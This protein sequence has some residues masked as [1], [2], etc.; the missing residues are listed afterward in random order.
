[1]YIKLSD[2]RRR[3]RD[4]IERDSERRSDEKEP[5]V[6]AVS[7]SPSLSSLASLF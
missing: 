4:K 2:G 5:T 1:L 7:L 6:S 3:R